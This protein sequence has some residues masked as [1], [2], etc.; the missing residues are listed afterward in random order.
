MS[1]FRRVPAEEEVSSSDESEHSDSDGGMCAKGSLLHEIADKACVGLLAVGIFVVVAI[2]V[3]LVTLWE[4]FLSGSV[5]I[6]VKAAFWNQLFAI[7]NSAT[8]VS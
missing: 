2:V 5:G 1:F 3:A 7:Q 4:S 6:S 8:S